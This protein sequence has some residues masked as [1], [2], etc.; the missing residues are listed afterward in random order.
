MSTQQKTAVI[1][2]NLGTPDSPDAGAVRRYLGEFL[3]DRRVVEGDGPR[4][5]LWLAV[6]HGIILR[7]RPGRVAKAYQ[8]IWQEDSP[9]RII[10]DKQVAALDLV[11]QQ[12]CGEQAPQ[13]FAAMTYGQPGLTECLES[14]GRNDYERVLVLPLYPQYSATT[15][16]PIYDQVARFQLNRREVMDIRILKSY[17]AHPLYINALANSV[18]DQ[19]EKTGTPDKL[20]LS[21]H[22][23]PQEYAD[24]GDPYPLQ[25]H[26]TSEL[27]A[28]ELGLADNAWVT[29]FQSR[30]GP[31]QW[32]TPYT[33][34]TLEKLPAQGIKNL[35]V[36]CPAFSADC[37]ETLEE[38]AEE[39]REVFMK[40]G[41]ES[42]NY[43]PALNAAPDF[44]ELLK[45]LVLEQA[46][47]WV[48]E[49]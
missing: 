10:L 29:T 44:I 43:I 34:K 13:V 37:L 1:L 46:G 15:T 24:K 49:R 17:Y 5:A 3:A 2:V 38:M 20:L 33:D 25:C 4:R 9:M 42:Y 19:L 21:Y 14:L 40:A 8:T 28:A 36:A 48:G 35:D 22:G 41:G 47:D 16:A 23:I 31:K 7:F 26:R 11:L 32:L 30:F 18:R 27:L 39:N 45:H 12:H 6:L